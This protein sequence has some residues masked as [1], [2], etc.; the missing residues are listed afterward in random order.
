MSLAPCEGTNT[1]TKLVLVK[2]VFGL[3]AMAFGA[4]VSKT[5]LNASLAGSGCAA[6]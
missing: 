3:F 6:G 5:A 1:H 2:K 4:G